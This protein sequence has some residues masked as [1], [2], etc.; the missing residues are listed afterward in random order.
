MW[1][2]SCICL[3]GQRKFTEGTYE[4]KLSLIPVVNSGTSR[5][6]LEV[7]CVCWNFL[8]LL[9]TYLEFV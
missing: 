3:E 1:C 5:Y 6:E 7:P 2:H 8:F 9:W 4:D